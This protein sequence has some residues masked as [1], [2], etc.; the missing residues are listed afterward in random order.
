[1]AAVAAVAAVVRE[2]RDPALM[3]TERVRPELRASMGHD[4][5]NSE[6]GIRLR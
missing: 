3:L 5:G 2:R 6:V 4:Q 1:V